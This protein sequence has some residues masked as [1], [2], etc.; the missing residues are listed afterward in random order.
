MDTLTFLLLIAMGSLVQT[1]TGFAM[2]LIVMGGVAL[3]GI[4]ELTSAAAVVS[5]VSMVNILVAL[6]RTYR[7]IHWPLV[8][9]VIVG[10]VPMVFVGVRVMDYI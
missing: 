5:L 8:K 10:M 3:L 2:G 4:L 9:A 6:R 1:I 7:F